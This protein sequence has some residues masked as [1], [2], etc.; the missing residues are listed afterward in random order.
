MP[1]D[2]KVEWIA[3]M[4]LSPEGYSDASWEI[5]SWSASFHLNCLVF[6]FLFLFLVGCACATIGDEDDTQRQ[7][8]RFRWKDNKHLFYMSIV[9]DPV[10]G[11]FIIFND[12]DKYTKVNRHKCQLKFIWPENWLGTVSKQINSKSETENLCSWHSRIE[13]ISG[14]NLI[15][16]I[17]T[18]AASSKMPF[19][20]RLP[21]TAYI[22]IVIMDGHVV[23][24]IAK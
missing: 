23:Q 1:A 13:I 8:Y 3:T 20:R 16:P 4:I 6:F 5:A 14:P 18:I 11:A 19:S 2:F 24:H 10:A 12:L 9:W 7:T 15:P 22:S 17:L 21:L